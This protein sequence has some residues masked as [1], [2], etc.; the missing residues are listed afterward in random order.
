MR[1]GRSV[2][3]V[4]Y[5]PKHA[6]RGVRLVHPHSPWDNCAH[7]LRLRLTCSSSG[8]VA[9]I[10]IHVQEKQMTVS[11]ADVRAIRAGLAR[12][13]RRSPLALMRAC[14]AHFNTSP[15][16]QFTQAHQKSFGHMLRDAG[17][18]DKH[19]SRDS[20]STMLAFDFKA[21]IFQRVTR[22]STS[23]AHVAAEVHP[24]AG[25]AF[26]RAAFSGTLPLLCSMTPYHGTIMGNVQGGT[27][28]RCADCSAGVPLR[29]LASLISSFATAPLIWPLTTPRASVAAK[30]PCP[31]V[32]VNLFFKEGL[33]GVRLDVGFWS[34]EPRRAAAAAATS[35]A[36]SALDLDDAVA[37][38]EAGERDRVLSLELA[39]R[40][41]VE[42]AEKER[43]AKEKVAL[44]AALRA[45]EEE[46]VAALEVAAREARAVAEQRVAAERTAKEQLCKQKS[47]SATALGKAR[48]AVNEWRDRCASFEQQLYNERRQPDEKVRSANA[49]ALAARAAAECEAARLAKSTAVAVAKRMAMIATLKRERENRMASDAMLFDERAQHE[50]GL[51]AVTSLPRPH[52]PMPSLSRTPSVPASLLEPSAAP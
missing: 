36:R 43:L 18:N 1:L 9:A 32:G 20:Q 14:Y 37:A 24:K 4:R 8:V 6:R 40:L 26:R 15:A 17:V 49:G 44:E 31:R 45:A 28:T 2:R 19:L 33:V 41:A 16:P 46:R 22:E 29:V 25:G 34:R 23:T 11:V 47:M 52:S 48:G 21:G 13:D 27:H 39:Q 42:Q 30:P 7:V 35:R 12:K 50:R 5:C 10:C 38:A 3:E 51:L